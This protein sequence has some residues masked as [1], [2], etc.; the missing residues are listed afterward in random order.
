MRAWALRAALA[1]MVSILCACGGRERDAQA[2]IALLQ[3]TLKDMAEG[4]VPLGFGV[5][6][7][8][9]DITAD[10]MEFAVGDAD[11]ASL[12][13]LADLNGLMLTQKE[14]K[15]EFNSSAKLAPLDEAWQSYL[16][17]ATA[18]RAAGAE[19]TKQ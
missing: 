19:G 3:L 12:S 10:S 17:D 13:W 2:A 14:L 1:A 6:R 5:N 8:Y 4:Y 15:A 18:S 9:G 7:G 16:T 11:V